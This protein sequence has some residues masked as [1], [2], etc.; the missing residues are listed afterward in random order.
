MEDVEKLVGLH[1]RSVFCVSLIGTKRKIYS[2][3]LITSSTLG[4]IG[5]VFQLFLWKGYLRRF[6]AR[7]KPSSNPH[8][9][10]SLAVGNLISTLGKL[11]QIQAFNYQFTVIVISYFHF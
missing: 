11:L 9:V 3:C 10:F 4:L 1:F 5:S 7:H 2:S 8:I 6:E